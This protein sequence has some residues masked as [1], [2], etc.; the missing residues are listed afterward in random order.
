MSSTK[1]PYLSGDALGWGDGKYGG[2][3]ETL[4]EKPFGYGGLSDINYNDY[5]EMYKLSST[6]NVSVNGQ[7]IINVFNTF[8]ADQDNKYI[9]ASDTIT[10][11]KGSTS[12]CNSTV[13]VDPDW[14]LVPPSVIVL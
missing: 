9:I 3:T 8:Y 7:K 1:K 6:A 10:H 11:I 5:Y 14:S 13:P 12:G 2:L 4:P